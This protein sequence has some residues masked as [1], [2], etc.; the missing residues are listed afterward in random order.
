MSL[1]NCEL[2]LLG[3]SLTGESVD[4]VGDTERTH[5]KFLQANCEIP[6]TVLAQ[7][8]SSNFN[9]IV[10]DKTARSSLGRRF[11]EIFAV[12]GKPLREMKVACHRG[13]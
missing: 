6:R 9:V 3:D 4:N 8:A 10:L 5:L 13:R 12:T 1:I 7:A 2:F 11:V